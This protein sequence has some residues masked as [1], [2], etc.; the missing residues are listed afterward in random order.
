MRP[1][2]VPPR[3]SASLRVPHAC[4]RRAS[5]HRG[6]RGS[7]TSPSTSP[8]AHLGVF[9]DGHGTYGTAARGSAWCLRGLA[10]GRVGSGESTVPCGCPVSPTYLQAAVCLQ[11]FARRKTP[12]TPV[13]RP[14]PPVP[15]CPCLS[16]PVPACARPR[17]GRRHCAP[18]PSAPRG[19]APGLPLRPRCLHS[20]QRDLFTQ[21]GR[22]NVSFLGKTLRFLLRWNP[23]SL[24]QNHDFQSEDSSLS[25][26]LT[27][28]RCLKRVVC[29]LGASSL[30]V[31]SASE[32]G[33]SVTRVVPVS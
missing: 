22:R 26:L 31:A 28:R 16:P 14:S 15:A 2:C 11:G 30:F 9:V 27:F 32:L 24:L 20:S 1:S 29:T 3:L 21:Q 23:N 10:C 12:L 4:G 5:L 18:A 17:V 8:V 19:C 6:S 13:C 7:F 25:H 33:A